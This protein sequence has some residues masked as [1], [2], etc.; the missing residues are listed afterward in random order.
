[1]YLDIDESDVRE[2]IDEQITLP[3]ATI[4]EGTSTY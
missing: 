4:T 3:S 1:M 2:I